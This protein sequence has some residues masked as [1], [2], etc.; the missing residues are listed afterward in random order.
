LDW[1]AA[2]AACQRDWVV[3]MNLGDAP[4]G[5]P[6]GRRPEEV[7]RSVGDAG[8][9]MVH[10][11]GVEYCVAE[12]TGHIEQAADAADRALEICLAAG[13]WSVARSASLGPPS[14]VTFFTNSSVRMRF[15]LRDVVLM[16]ERQR[17]CSAVDAA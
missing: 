9:G 15:L 7:L 13:F 14:C 16:R 10:V 8:Y 12:A 17:A 11:R 3:V 2:V 6:D 1:E 5:L 4:R